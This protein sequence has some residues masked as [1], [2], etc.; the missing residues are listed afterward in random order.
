MQN[1]TRA[2]FASLQDEFAN[3]TADQGLGSLGEWPAE[4]NH[5]CYV[6]DMTVDTGSTF[7]EAIAAGGTEFPGTTIQF[8]YQLI[9]DPDHEEP[10][11]F[12]GAPITFPNDPSDLSHEG[13][14]IRSRIEIQR[15]KGHI[16]TLLGKEPVDMASSMDELQN[17]LTN[18]EATVAATIRCAYNTRNNRTYRT[19]YVQTL[20]GG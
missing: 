13:S 18:G 15:L 11:V 16:K 7:R 8:R 6:L 17:K 3:A 10:L 4:G 19:E 14:K 9:D 2:I 1:Q 12:R 5:D 20:L